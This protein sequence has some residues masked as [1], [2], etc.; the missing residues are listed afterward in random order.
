MIR[1]A[2]GTAFR[3][4][5]RARSGPLVV[6][7]EASVENVRF[8]KHP[9]VAGRFAAGALDAAA[10]P[11]WAN[12]HTLP[13]AAQVQEQRYRRR[14]RVGEGRSIGCHVA[15]LR[16]VTSVMVLPS[17]DI[18]ARESNGDPSAI[19]ASF[20]RD[21]PGTTPITPGDGRCTLF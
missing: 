18:V 13:F 3:A 1:C 16:A 15:V 8:S 14:E 21:P 20:N 19:A 9:R 17:A 6:I 4:G 10:G 5:P 7:T 11:R 2:K 12:Q